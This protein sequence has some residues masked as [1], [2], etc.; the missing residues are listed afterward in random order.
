[1]MTSIYP[2][3]SGMET[4]LPKRFALLPSSDGSMKVNV[5]A[6]CVGYVWSEKEKWLAK[7][8]SGAPLDTGAGQ[9]VLE[10]VTAVFR[11]YAD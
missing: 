5:A 6:R 9:S 8:S 2:N 3:I 11:A 7:D 1:M 10:A 4:T